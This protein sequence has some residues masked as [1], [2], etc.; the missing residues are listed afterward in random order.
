M[1]ERA[2]RAIR[3]ALWWCRDG[4]PFGVRPVTRD[5]LRILSICAVCH[6][7]RN[8]GGDW[9]FLPETWWPRPHV[10]SHGYCPECAEREV[11]TFAA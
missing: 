1:S 11:G 5:G 9:E 2:E 7:V 10:L 3:F 4:I 8:A 6:R